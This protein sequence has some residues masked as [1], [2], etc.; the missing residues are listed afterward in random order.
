MIAGSL[1]INGQRGSTLQLDFEYL[2]SNSNLINISSYE[3]H[4]IVK[5]TSIKTDDFMF[6]IKAN[7]A[8]REGSIPFPSTSEIYGSIVRGTT[9]KFTLTISN[10]TMETLSPGTYFYSLYLSSLAPTVTPLAKGRFYVESD[11]K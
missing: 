10:E 9:G 5:K 11:V 4:F 3:I 8:S 7:S 1:D 2:D 6:E